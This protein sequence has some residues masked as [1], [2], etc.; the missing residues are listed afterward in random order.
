MSA[1]QYT[2]PVRFALMPQPLAPIPSVAAQIAEA[3]AG[4]VGARIPE[5]F[6]RMDLPPDP[7]LPGILAYNRGVAY[8]NKMSAA[9]QMRVDSFAKSASVEGKK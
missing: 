9:G 4:L 3:R 6:W 2:Y 7:R 5:R 8:W 1:S